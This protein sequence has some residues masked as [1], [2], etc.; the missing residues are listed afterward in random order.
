MLSKSIVGSLTFRRGNPTGRSWT[1]G[2]SEVSGNRMLILRNWIRNTALYKFARRR[3]FVA[4][5][6]LSRL[7]VKDKALPL[8]QVEWLSSTIITGPLRGM[9]LVYP[10]KFENP[11]FSLGI[12]ERHVAA[13]IHHF[14]R[15]G[16]T[17]YD[18]GANIGYHSLHAFKA[19]GPNGTVYSF[20]PNP[21][22]FAALG[23]C[24]QSNNLANVRAL[25]V[26]VAD[27]PGRVRFATF[28]EPGISHIQRDTSP[29]GA[30]TIEVEAVAIDDLVYNKGLR[31]PR[32]IKIDVEGGELAVL[33]GAQEVLADCGPT[34][35]SEVWNGNS[36]EVMDLLA[37][38]G[39]ESQMLCGYTWGGD[40]LFRRKISRWSN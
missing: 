35:V 6:Q 20:E 22:D 3:A 11:T 27:K 26:A 39:Y 16:D 33:R 23:L 13:T 32:F 15:P 19:A 1:L 9:R 4:L 37:H 17:V 28:D 10:P 2:K 18:V 21:P 31:P 24:I 30:P 8:R 40:Y 12:F 36:T 38:C 29:V 34:I 25:G 14:V 5:C 7:A